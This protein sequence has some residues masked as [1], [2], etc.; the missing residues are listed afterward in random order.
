MYMIKCE[1]IHVRGSITTANI[2]AVK[3]YNPTEF[4][5]ILGNSYHRGVAIYDIDL[6]LITLSRL[7]ILKSWYICI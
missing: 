7:D 3:M 2:F 5:F 4:I 6:S 1:H